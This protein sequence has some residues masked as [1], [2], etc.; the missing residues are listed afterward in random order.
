MDIQLENLKRFLPAEVT[1][2]YLAIQKILSAH[3][4]KP[5]ELM[6]LMILMGVVLALA[7]IFIYWKYYK[8]RS[9]I[10]HGCILIGFIIWILNI[11]TPR[12]V[13]LQVVGP[14]IEIIAPILLVLYSVAT[15]IFPIPGG[16]T[17][18]K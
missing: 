4:E 1:A 14:H 8:F 9:P 18:G 15:S 6:G 7:N 13:D 17:N 11:D 10:A 16:P 12:Y 3:G 5:T 2:A